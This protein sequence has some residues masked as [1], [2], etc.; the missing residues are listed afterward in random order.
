MPLT[1][2]L[3]PGSPLRGRCL[4]ISAEG[5]K[6]KL[7]RHVP[8]GSIMRLEMSF[9]GESL[10]VAARLGYYDQDCCGLIFEFST[11]EERSSLGRLLQAIQ[12][13]T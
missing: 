8:V 9:W 11:D 5:M 10:A 2:Y 3:T 1:F 4:D 13:V 6:A 12:K 7:D